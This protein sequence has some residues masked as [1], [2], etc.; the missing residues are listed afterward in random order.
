VGREALLAQLH[1]RL[2]QAQAGTWQVLLLRGEAGL[3]KTTVVET[4]L[5]QIAAVPG[6]WLGWGQCLAAASEAYFPVLEALGQLGR[7]VDQAAL[8]RAL[9]QH[10]PHWLGQLPS[11]LDATTLDTV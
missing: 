8:V 1:A 6:L 4:F 11:C 3:G 5:A 2:A 9:L 10:A 7:G